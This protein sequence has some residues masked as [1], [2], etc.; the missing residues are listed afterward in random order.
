MANQKH[1]DILS[2]GVDLW[3]QWRV[4]SYEEV[5]NLSSANLASAN[6]S[7]INFIETDLR[8]ADLSRTDLRHAHMIDAKVGSAMLSG[9]DLSNSNLRRAD[10]NTADLSHARIDGASLIEAN[11]SMANLKE[12]SLIGADLAGSNLYGVDFR[13]ADLREA[14]LIG[15]RLVEANLDNANITN[16]AV[17]GIA[18]WN[19]SLDRAIQSNL[20]ITRYGEPTITVDNLE[21]A[22]FIYLLLNNTKVRDVIDT[23][24][25]KAVLILGRFTPERKA[26]L[27]AIRE[28]LRKQDYLPILFDFDMPSSRDLTETITLLAR[29]ARFI[30]AD[31]TEPCSIFKELEAIVPNVTV[32]VQP[33]LEG[34]TRP[35]TMFRD[36]WKYHW[37][38][39]VYRYD[40]V[41]ELIGSLREKVLAPAEAKVEELEKR[42]TEAAAEG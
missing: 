26:V 20:M 12:A 35:Y 25:S 28:E 31:L 14:I 1:L 23:I 9:A 3:N 37:M 7:K 17:Y 19:V 5:P 38:L 15:S 6:L 42:R 2:K 32:P 34:Q 36:Y 10:L 27:D 21:V 16:S 40:E 22:Q 30:I 13:G 24:T 29:M 18:A 33:L 39:N 41:E 8:S 11:L 4:E